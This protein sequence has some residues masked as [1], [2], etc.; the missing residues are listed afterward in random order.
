MVISHLRADDLAAADQLPVDDV[1]L[2]GLRAV[3]RVVGAG[4]AGEATAACA[5]APQQARGGGRDGVAGPSWGDEDHNG[6]V[7]WDRGTAVGLIL[8]TAAEL[9]GMETSL[10]VGIVV[11]PMG[12]EPPL[13]VGTIPTPLAELAGAE[14]SL[15]VGLRPIGVKLLLPAGKV[16]EPAEIES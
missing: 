15:P 10:P 5:A 3:G 12:A 11:K 1:E 6:L 7:G 2:H 14:P 9:M 4:V 13:F 16:A 8:D